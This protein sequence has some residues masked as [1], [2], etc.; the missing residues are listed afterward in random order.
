[1]DIILISDEHPNVAG[2]W[3]QVWLQPDV[4]VP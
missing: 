1:M 2:G 3:W 4:A